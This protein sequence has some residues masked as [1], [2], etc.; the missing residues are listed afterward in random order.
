[1]KLEVGT[2]CFDPSSFYL[3]MWHEVVTKKILNEK[4]EKCASLHGLCEY[5]GNPNVVIWDCHIY[6]HSI[7][8]LVGGG[9]HTILTT[10]GNLLSIS[11]FFLF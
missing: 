7:L 9:G 6:I 11:Q 3:T 8:V 5:I 4:K 1:M 10:W 2:T